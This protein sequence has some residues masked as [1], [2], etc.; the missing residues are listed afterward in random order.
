MRSPILIVILATVAA[1][2]SGCV[3]TK[4]ADF[5]PTEATRPQKIGIHFDASVS[6]LQNGMEQ[7][8]AGVT[9]GDLYTCI[10]TCVLECFGKSYVEVVDV[11]SLPPYDRG[12]FERSGLDCIL[13]IGLGKTKF[14]VPILLA[15]EGYRGRVVLDFKLHD[16]SGVPVRSGSVEGKAYDRCLVL[17]LADKKILSRVCDNAVRDAVVKLREAIRG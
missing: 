14:S 13:V 9:Q 10:R 8:T 5:V 3:A 2:V 4:P 15:A 12:S 16:T 6:A 7:V 11:T 1:L 17:R